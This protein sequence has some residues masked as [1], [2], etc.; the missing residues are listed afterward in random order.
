MTS[1][2]RKT[3]IHAN[4]RWWDLELTEFFHYKDLLFLL[5]RRD[6]V[7]TYKQTVLGPLWVVIQALMGSAVFTVI[8][9][10]LAGLS[11]DGHPKFLF[12]LCG[13]LAWQ[14]FGGVFGVGS[15]ALQSNLSLF[16]KVYFPRLIPPISQAI[17]GLFN[18]FF[19]LIVYFLAL[20]IHL[21]ANPTSS[22]G[23]R[24]EAFLLPFL[25]FQ[26]A[27][28]GLGMGFIISSASVKYRDLGRLAGLLTQFLMYATPVIYPLSQ[29]PEVYREY[30]A[31]NPL[32]LIVESYRYL[33]LGEAHGTT[34]T[35]AIPSIALTLFIFLLGL[36]LYNKTQRTY[37]DY[38]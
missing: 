15:H 7:T 4:R 16:A 23:L 8:F 12:Y 34:I 14:Y 22:A 21:S 5:V 2:R 31:W 1:S 11:T 3:L 26:S 20:G 28:L 10:N 27:L 30:M 32:T 29:I 9:G 13:T 18:F 6:F 17:S 19:Q 25:I 36:I 33:L 35:Y 37:V 24:I 38:I